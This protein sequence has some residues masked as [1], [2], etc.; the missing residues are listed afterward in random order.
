MLCFATSAAVNSSKGMVGAGG[1]MR[2]GVNGKAMQVKDFCV[3]CVVDARSISRMK[4]VPDEKLI[5]R[6]VIPTVISRS[7]RAA[8]AYPRSIWLL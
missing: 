5:G 7:G 1:V 4:R 8:L 3:G 6:G 2:V